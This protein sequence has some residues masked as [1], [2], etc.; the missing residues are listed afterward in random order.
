MVAELVGHRCFFVLMLYSLR[1]ELLVW[2]VPVYVLAKIIPR[3]SLF[4]LFLF[5]FGSAAVL[6]VSFDVLLPHV[7]SYVGFSGSSESGMDLIRGVSDARFHRQF[8]DSDGSGG[9]SNHVGRVV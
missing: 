5:L 8:N 6:L 2:I 9:F 4:S 1:P 7:F 3:I